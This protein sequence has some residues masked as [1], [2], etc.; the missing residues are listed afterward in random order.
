MID[1]LDCRAS[2]NTVFRQPNRESESE[3]QAG[4]RDLPGLHATIR[5]VAKPLRSTTSRAW[6]E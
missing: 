3:V 2:V 6:G 4:A 1:G 5:Q